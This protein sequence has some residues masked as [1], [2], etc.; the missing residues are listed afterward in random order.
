MI[1]DLERRGSSEM[2][3]TEQVSYIK[4]NP[5]GYWTV[6]FH[7]GGKV[8]RYSSARLIYMTQPEEVDLT[9]RGMYIGNRRI[10]EVVRLLRFISEQGVFYTAIYASG[11]MEHMD[12]CRVYVTRTPID[13]IDASVWSYLRKLAEETGLLSPNGQSLLAMQYELVDTKRDH[14]PLAQYLGDKTKLG[15]HKLPRGVYYPFG[16]NAS[17]KQAVERALTHQLSVIQGPPGT[18]K[19]QTILNIIANLVLEGKSVLV[20][21]N[22]NSAVDAVAEKLEREGLGFLVAQLGSAE[23]NAVFLQ[24]QITQLPDLSAWSVAEPG[25]LRQSVG[26]ALGRVVQGLADQTAQATLRAQ[27]EALELEMRHRDGVP[28]PSP[29]PY[30]WLWRRSSGELMTLLLQVRSA[31]EAE[32]GFSLWQR[33]LF[34]LRYGWSAFTTLGKPLDE[35]VQVMEQV[36]YRVY[37]AECRAELERIERRLMDFDLGQSLS[38]LSTQSLRYLKHRVAERYRSGQ[39]RHYRSAQEI[40][41]DTPRFLEQYPIVL[42]TTHSAKGCIDPNYVFDYVIMDEASQVDIKT[43]ALC[44][45]C[46]QNAVIVGDDKQLPR[47]M[48]GQEEQRL[49]IIQEL[50]QVPEVYHG[51]KHSFLTSCIARLPDAPSTLLREHYRC[52]PKII[53]FCNQ[54][55]YDGELIPMTVDNGEQGVIQ[56]IRTAAGG[57]NRGLVNEREVEVIKQELMP[58]LGQMGTVGIITPYRPQAEAINQALGMDIASTVHSYQGR[59]CDTIIL[60]MVK[61]TPTKFSNK[62]DLINVAVSRAKKRLYIVTS[63]ND[64]PEDSNLAQLI[65]Y[66]QYHGCQVQESTLRSV[67]DLLYSQYTAER[68]AYLGA[69]PLQQGWYLSERLVYDALMEAIQQIGWDCIGVLCHYPLAQLIQDWSLLSPQEQAF[70]QSSLAHVDFLLYNTLTKRPLMV[71][72]V[73]GWSYHQG[74]RTQQARDALKDGIL[75]RYGLK[76][77][78]LSTTQLVTVQ[79]LVEMLERALS[80]DFSP[81]AEA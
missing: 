13:Q 33:L 50:Y 8:F 34:A 32:Q 16:C 35:V 6:G 17:Q 68:L 12:G 26:N 44:L 19:T 3:I 53:G 15:Q 73:D 20:V 74:S 22:N 4:R 21:S 7:A 31:L 37:H 42:S 18:G 43:G 27:V 76:P 49:S 81:R 62:D 9:E 71:I 54:R 5:E 61:S 69:K 79:S 77:H 75:H 72:E 46:A 60:S 23:R 14:V 55:F 56:V 67:F 1:I 2:F 66:A 63:S 38:E 58:Q 25:A 41:A 80:A 52:H 59:E 39:R 28:E 40:K 78:R 29:S 65:A 57:H 24:G 10:T 11:K 30:A 70:A 48:T 36:Y 47:I 45:A 51:T 64:L